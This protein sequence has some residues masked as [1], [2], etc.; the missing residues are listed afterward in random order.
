MSVATEA[1]STMATAQKCGVHYTTVRRWILAGQLPA[2]QTPGGHLRIFRKD[3]DSFIASRRFNPAALEAACCVP[4]R[5]QMP[6]GTITAPTQ[7]VGAPDRRRPHVP[8]R[9]LVVD[10]DETLRDSIAE[11]LAREAKL[12]VQGAGDGFSAARLVLEFD[13]D[14]V[15][16]DLLMPGLDGH[17]V[18]RNIRGSSRTTHIRILVLTGFPTEENIRKAMDAGA[19][20]CLAKPVELDE[21]QNELLCLLGTGAEPAQ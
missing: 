16:L 19:D 20:A 2:Y 9:V 4:T 3:V 1:L 17:A 7:A 6:D 5:A 21:L 18:C 10:D 11:F 13:P 14:A 15:I 8:P 12:Q